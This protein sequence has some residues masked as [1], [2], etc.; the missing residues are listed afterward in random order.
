MANHFPVVDHIRLGVLK[1]VD[2]IGKDQDLVHFIGEGTS[3]VGPGLDQNQDRS[4]RKGEG[5]QSRDQNTVKRDQSPEDTDQE[6]CLGPKPKRHN[7]RAD[8]DE[9]PIREQAPDVGVNLMKPKLEGDQSQG[10]F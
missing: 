2:E 4:R 9:D 10:A 1:N 7:R 6:V 5:N 8:G 3:E